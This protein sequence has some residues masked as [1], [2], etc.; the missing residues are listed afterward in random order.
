[1]VRAITEERLINDKTE[2]DQHDATVVALADGTYAVAW[3]DDLFAPGTLDPFEVPE[4][5]L[6]FE[7]IRLKPFN[8]VGD[9]VGRTILVSDP[10]LTPARVFYNDLDASVAT[11]GDVVFAWQV[12]SIDGDFVQTRKVDPFLNPLPG[13]LS[14]DYEN[15]AI[16]G[17]NL[18]PT[19]DGDY[20]LAYQ[21]SDSAKLVVGTPDALESRDNLSNA[22]SPPALV[23][24]GDGRVGS[25]VVPLPSVVD[26][27]LEFRILTPDGQP[28]AEPTAILNVD[29]SSKSVTAELL[30]GGLIA[31]VVEGIAVLVDQQGAVVVPAFT[32]G[33]PGS[34]IGDP[35]VAALDGGG[36]LIAWVDRN[37]QTGDG[38]GS[39]IKAQAFSSMGAPLGEEIVVNTTTAGNQSDP[40]I[41]TLANGDVVVTWTD[42]SGTGADTSGTSIRAAI[43]STDA[44]DVPVGAQVST[45][46]SETLRATSAADIFFFDTDTGTSLGTDVIKSFGAG[47][48]LVTTSKLVDPNDDGRIRFD[49]SD[50][51]SLF[52]DGP[53]SE[54]IVSLKVFYNSGKALSNLVL[55]DEE[56]HEGAIYY[57]YGGAGD[58]SASPELFF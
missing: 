30:E 56:V 2:N 6:E 40:S 35:Q 51:L 53:D 21:S 52:E 9:V 26:S 4:Y 33:G 38:S 49:S 27:P 44:V 50:R 11:N 18:S 41:A 39:A 24:L 34:R 36:F 25:F 58:L 19:I 28:V 7:Q 54:L 43:L 31:V 45:G 10:S 46:A 47:D 12:N 1:M 42:S 15:A 13:V 16:V 37:P 17:P 23:S 29:A 8:A 32:Y 55:L 20:L 3:V 57:V 14:T 48:R 22:W 5:V